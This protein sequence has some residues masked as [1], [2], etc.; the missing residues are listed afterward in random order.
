MAPRL[1]KHKEHLD[2]TLST[3]IILGA[4]QELDF[5]GPYGLLLTQVIL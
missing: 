4:V 1:P 3:C 5:D 2:N